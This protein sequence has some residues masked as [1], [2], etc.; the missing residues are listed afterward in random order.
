MYAVNASV[1]KTLMREIIAY[2]S[3]VAKNDGNDRL[4][5]VLRDVIDTP[6]SPELLP[7]TD[8]EN[9]QH[10]ESIVGPYELHDF[11]L[12]YTVKYGYS[13][14]K[15]FRMACEAFS[16][17]GAEEIKKYL[18]VF[19]RRFY[20]QQFKRS[21]LP[22]GPRVTEISLSPRGAWQMPSDVSANIWRLDVNSI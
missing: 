6:V 14:K 20:S 7:L 12:Y 10:T 1:P 9:L 16:E 15:V 11:F 4:S 22:D 3:T 19:V 8:G 13:P 2:A 21:C 17:Y 5:S 18:D